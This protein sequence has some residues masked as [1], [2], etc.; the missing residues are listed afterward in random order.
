[1]ENSEKMV[2]EL[3]DENLYV[4]F[5]FQAYLILCVQRSSA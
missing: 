3:S 1:M 2:R 5:Y 4:F